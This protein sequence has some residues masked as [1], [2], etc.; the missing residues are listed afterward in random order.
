MLQYIIR[1]ILLAVPTM[2]VISFLAFALGK[3]APGDPVVNVFGE[4]SYL[5]LDPAAQA[6]DFNS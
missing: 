5:T 3:Y 2:L 6:V 1:R 4:T